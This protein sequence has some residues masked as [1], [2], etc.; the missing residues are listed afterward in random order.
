MGFEDK[1]VPLKIGVVEEKNEFLSG[2]GKVGDEVTIS[3]WKEV[4]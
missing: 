3:L 1:T 4:F 2:L